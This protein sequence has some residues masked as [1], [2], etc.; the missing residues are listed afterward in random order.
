M[1]GDNEAGEERDAGVSCVPVAVCRNVSAVG[2]EI[3]TIWVIEKR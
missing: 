3:W 1:W 2:G